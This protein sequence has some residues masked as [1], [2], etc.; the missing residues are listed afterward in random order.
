[1]SSVI[2][3]F[4]LEPVE[5][6]AE[7]LRRYESILYGG[8]PAVTCP[9]NRMKIHDTTVELGTVPYP[10]DSTLGWG[11]D[12]VP[13]DDPRWPQVCDVCGTP[14]KSTDCWQ[15]NMERL[16]K[17]APDGKLYTTRNMPPG[18]MFNADWLQK[19]PDG[20]ALAVV[21]PSRDLWCPDMPSTSGTPWTRTGTIPK[22]TCTPS[23]LTSRYHGFLTDGFL[24]EV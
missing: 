7:S 20:I 21:L 17:G 19:G 3:C 1:M 22:V 12:D 15:H 13:H 23:I 9:Q 11:R 4:W 5:L 6:G 8:A 2:E 16:F 24:R 14:F 18:A 10:F